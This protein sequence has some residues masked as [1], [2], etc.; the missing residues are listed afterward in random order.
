LPYAAMAPLVASC[1]VLPSDYSC[2][3]FTCIFVNIACFW[4]D[5]S[6]DSGTVAKTEST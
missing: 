4:A 6:G 3:Y 2:W 1:S 5:S